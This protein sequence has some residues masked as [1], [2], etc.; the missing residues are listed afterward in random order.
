MVF[1]TNFGLET[2]VQLTSLSLNLESRVRVSSLDALVGKTERKAIF[3]M[4]SICHLAIGFKLQRFGID[5][6]M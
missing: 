3:Q 1:L 6:F 5:L 4:N 2:R